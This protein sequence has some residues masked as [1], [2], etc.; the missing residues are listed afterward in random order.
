MR[1]DGK[2]ALVT[3]AGSHGI[4]RAIALGFAR[5]GAD[6]AIHYH[7][8][9]EVAASV[10]AEIE[11]LGRRSFALQADLCAAEAGRQLV[12]AA[13]ERLGG[14]DI[15]LTAAAAIYRKP[16]LEITDAEWDHM[17]ALNLR[18]TFACATE[19]AR[20]MRSA[21]TK[22]RIILVGSI[23]Q[24]LALAGQVAYGVTKAGVAQL[25][26]GL[27]YELAPDAITVNVIAPGA[28]LTDFYRDYLA[29]PEVR[30]RR[31]AAI[32]MGRLGDPEDMVEAAL[33]L[34][35]PGAAYTTGI[36]IFVDGGVMLP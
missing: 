4:G 33:Y 3:G 8:R 18:G 13:S 19:A 31:E 36:T 26:R 12:R 1:L 28:T 6:V 20:L 5:E 35:S 14:L 22:G 27:A 34:A 10:V 32:P 29:D 25:A 16:T 2:K 7:S 9:P 15:I 21:G 17:M 30:A 24:Q 23:V 11:A